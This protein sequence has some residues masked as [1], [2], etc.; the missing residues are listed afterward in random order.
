MYRIVN[1]FTSFD[2]LTKATT[3]ASIR[4]LVRQSKASDCQ[5]VTR[6]YETDDEGTPVARLDWNGSHLEVIETY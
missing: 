4:R 3:E 6:I 1:D 5:S 2:K